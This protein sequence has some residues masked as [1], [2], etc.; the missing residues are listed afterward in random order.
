MFGYKIIS[1]DEYEYLVEKSKTFDEFRQTILQSEQKSKS[2]Q[3]RM[4]EL[5]KMLDDKKIT[6]EQYRKLWRENKL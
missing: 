4:L 6:Y 5:N 3:N 2:F 1:Q